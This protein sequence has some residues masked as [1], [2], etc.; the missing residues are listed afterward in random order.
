MM[1]S[2][3]PADYAKWTQPGT[4]FTVA[5]PVSLFHEIDFFVNEG[6][7][8]I[9]YGGIEVGGLLF[10]KTAS[11]EIRIEAFRPIECEHASGPSFKL[12]ERDV[13]ALRKQIESSPGDPEL[14]ASQVVGWFISHARS[15]LQMNDTEAALFDE[16][17]PGPDKITLL[18]KP[19]KFKS[20]RFSFLVRAP[21]GLMNL[22]GTE[23][24][25]VLPLPGRAGRAQTAVS[26][27]AP[28]PA[29][30][31]KVPEIE[32]PVEQAAAP[33]PERIGPAPVPAAPAPPPVATIPAPVQPN[34]PYTAERIERR[35]LAR[36]AQRESSGS[37]FGFALVLLLAGVLG[38]GL[39]YWA[40]LQLPPAVIPLN[41]E[42]GPAGFTLTWPPEITRDAVYVAM[43]VNDGEPVLVSARDRM[44]G[45]SEINVTGGSAKVELIARRWMRDSR[46]IVRYVG[47][48]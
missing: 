4:S 48:G 28:H 29:V 40:Y 7:R 21:D 2:D 32:K 17:L 36:A 9:A 27:P 20:T 43:R 19:E 30:V 18:V 33:V 26:E 14:S 16:L 38:C 11:N 23:Q 24:T 37:K 8:R 47:P 15:E 39:G 34:V 42:P 46:G 44:A 6:Y 35:R 10:G 3:L 31:E 45:R 25:F 41:L 13:A 22:D 5:Y 1:G 12:S